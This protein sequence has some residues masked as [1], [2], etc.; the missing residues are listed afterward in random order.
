[1]V[2]AGA[3]GIFWR[4]ASS[5]GNRGG[6]ARIRTPA[7]I[8]VDDTTPEYVA[9]SFL[10]AWRKRDYA[11]AERLSVEEA[12]AMVRD[13]RDRDP[14]GTNPQLEGIWEQMASER[15]DFAVDESENVDE[16]TLRLVGIARGTFLGEPYAREIAFVVRDTADGWRVVEVTFG[17]ILEG[18]A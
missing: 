15:L 1:M 7:D 14:S 4:S 17:D 10:D 13:R 11:I 9:E 2:C 3:L 12:R 18:G 6:N 8:P 16:G 5:A